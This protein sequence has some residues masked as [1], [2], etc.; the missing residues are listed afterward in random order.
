MMQIGEAAQASRVSTKRIRH[1]EEIGLI[2]APARR[3][4]NYREYT[5]DDVRRL[6]FV[7]RSRALG[8]SLPQIGGL[9]KLWDNRNRTC[10][11]VQ[12][13]ALA[14]VASLESKILAMREMIDEL[15]GLLADCHGN[16]SPDCSILKGLDGSNKL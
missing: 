3:T 1:Y 7:R 15:Q 11:E 13:V 2:P 4:G 5:P 6:E 9:L 14:H 16:D 10:A 12:S 8:F